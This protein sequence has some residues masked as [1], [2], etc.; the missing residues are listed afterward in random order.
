MSGVS[1]CLGKARWHSP[2]LLF[3]RVLW[4]GAGLEGLG[5]QSLPSL[6]QQEFA[7]TL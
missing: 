6:Q 4:C 3:R 2:E 1:C 7:H 5:K